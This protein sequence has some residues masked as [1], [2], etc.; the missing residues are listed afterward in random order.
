MQVWHIPQAQLNT[1]RRRPKIELLRCLLHMQLRA[2]MLAP[3]VRAYRFLEV[4]RFV[5]ADVQNNA[6]VFRF[7]ARTFTSAR[8]VLAVCLSTGVRCQDYARSSTFQHAV[9]WWVAST[10]AGHWRPSAVPATACWTATDRASQKKTRTNKPEAKLLR[11]TYD[12]FVSTGQGASY[13]IMSPFAAQSRALVL[14]PANQLQK[15]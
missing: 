6:G 4:S 3:P 15:R 11:G 7:F 1:L 5:A 14:A 2:S 12:V 8:P 9:E 13:T 10:V